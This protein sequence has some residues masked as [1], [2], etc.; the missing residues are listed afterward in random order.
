V[1]A[2]ILSLAAGTLVSE[3]LTCVGAGWMVATGRAG[4]LEAT[5]GCLIGIFAGDLLLHLAGA[6][7]GRPALRRAPLKWLLREGD[8]ERASAWF[9][10]RGRLAVV[11]SRPVPGARLPTYFS[12]GLF[13]MGFGDFALWCLAGAAIWTPLLVGSSA[14]AGDAASRFPGPRL[15]PAL[16]VA[17]AIAVLFV[18]RKSP[19]IFTWRGRRLLVGA[20]RRWRRWEFWPPWIFYPPI[21]GYVLWLG[22]RHRGFTL[23]TAANPGIEAGGFIG[24]SKS[25]ILRALERG[26]AHVARFRLVPGGLPV[27]D[28]A[29]MVAGFMKEEGLGYPIVLKPDVGQRG[30]GVEV[31]RSAERLTGYL[32]AS[33]HDVIA[34]EYVSG[35]ELGL[36]YFR[37][38]GERRGRLLSITEK[39]IPHVV[40]DGRRTIEDLILADE[41]A[42][43]MARVYATALQDRLAMVPRAGERV[44]LVEIG[45]H[46]RGAVFLDGVRARTEALEMAI[47]DASRGFEGFHF[48]RYDVRGASLEDLEA[49][50]GLR[51]LELN[52]VSSE[53]TDIYDPKNGLLDAYRRL[54]EQW[55][56]AFE[57]GRANRDLGHRPASLRDLLRLALAY[58]RGL[59]PL[60]LPAGGTLRSIRSGR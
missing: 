34:Q 55:R 48:G 25:R 31:V 27:P 26:G 22:L 9:E 18:A 10:R 17:G 28:R 44:A 11:L 36:F 21:V 42:V 14:L 50:R 2:L 38:P 6:H 12:A 53:S 51:I 47:D 3:D 49:G 13:G 54:R 33:P 56:I 43:C 15:S 40:G 58:R 29:A 60:A 30:S 1:V 4:F 5:L 20:W 39:S 45:T 46:C 59:R 16:A 57:I 41:R 23:F 8:V 37:R 7:L 52:G 24:E 19:A 35:P 32:E